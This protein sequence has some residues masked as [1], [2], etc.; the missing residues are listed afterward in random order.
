MNY[1]RDSLQNLRKALKSSRLYIVEEVWPKPAG[2]AENPD[3]K[4]VIQVMKDERVMKA[5]GINP[6]QDEV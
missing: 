4:T 1:I 6:H 2:G 3:R 5:L